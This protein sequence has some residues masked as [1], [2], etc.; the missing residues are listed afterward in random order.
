MEPLNR[1]ELR[2]NV[3]GM[4]EFTRQHFRAGIAANR[5]VGFKMNAT[6]MHMAPKEWAQLV[7]ELNTQIIWNYRENMLK[8]SIGRYPFYFLHDNSTVG[9]MSSDMTLEDRCE[10]GA[11]CRFNVKPRNLHC[12]LL[13][14]QSIQGLMSD[15]ID[16]ITVDANREKC[17]LQVPYEDYLHYP[18]ETIVQIER[19]LGLQPYLTPARR[20]KATSDNMCDV[21]K[22]MPEIC[23]KFA[24]CS[25]WGWM[26]NDESNGC[27]CADFEYESEGGDGENAFCGLEKLKGEDSWCGA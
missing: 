25:R 14:S 9:G 17:I 24:A 3:T 19:F 22:N 1:P 2:D 12:L 8:R 20:A 5:V 18:D 27:S 16:A 21:I 15:G 6:P 7:E 11:R 10:E 26:L 23:S 13:R 4:L